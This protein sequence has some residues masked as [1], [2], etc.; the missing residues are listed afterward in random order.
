MMRKTILLALLCL[1]AGLF[2]RIGEGQAAPPSP[3]ELKQSIE[4][5]QTT[6]AEN[7]K[8]LHAYDDEMRKT[9]G[10]DPASIRR[11]EEIRILKRYYAQETETLRARIIEDYKKIQEYRAGGAK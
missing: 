8:I 11:R 9:V 10:N 3:A 7:T 4:T 1:W 2:G 5:A 6:I